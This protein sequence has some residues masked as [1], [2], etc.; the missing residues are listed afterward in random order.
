MRVSEVQQIRSDND[1]VR[2]IS[3]K[4]TDS[5]PSNGAQNLDVLTSE[6]QMDLRPIRILWQRIDSRET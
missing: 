4:K 6:G 1:V 5:R 3:E 2:S